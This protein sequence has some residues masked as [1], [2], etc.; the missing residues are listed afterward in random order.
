MY[1]FTLISFTDRFLPISHC[2]KACCCFLFFFHIF[3]IRFYLFAVFRFRCLSFYY[4]D[5]NWHIY[6]FSQPII[7]GNSDKPLKCDYPN[8]SYGCVLPILLVRHKR[9][10]HSEGMPSALLRAQ[11]K[12]YFW[13]WDSRNQDFL[14]RKARGICMQGPWMSFVLSLGGGPG[15]TRQDPRQERR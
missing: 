11:S 8:C 14:C 9:S 2:F 6:L 4:F 3:L 7:G 5:I 13:K 12:V 1:F 10:V 15:E